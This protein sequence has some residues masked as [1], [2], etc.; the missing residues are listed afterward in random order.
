M[1]GGRSQVPRVR[2]LLSALGIAMASSRFPPRDH[3]AQT[4]KEELSMGR[5][6]LAALYW[7]SSRS[8]VSDGLSGAEMSVHEV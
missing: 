1:G 4:P 2:T 5:T 8:F 3:R 7:A 6:A